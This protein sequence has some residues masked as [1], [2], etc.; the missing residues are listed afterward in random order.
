VATSGRRLLFILEGGRRAL[1]E[2]AAVIEEAANE[3]EGP[4][5]R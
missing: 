5:G 4:S 2:A 3:Q 1:H